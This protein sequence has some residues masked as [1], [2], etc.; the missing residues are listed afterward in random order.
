MC[1]LIFAWKIHD[2]FPLT[3][4]A[5]RDEL[6]DRP[7]LSFS[8]HRRQ[9]PRIV[10]GRDLSAGGTWLAINEYGVI[11]GL[12]NAPS[13]DGRDA[14]K[15]SRGELP[16]ILSGFRKAADGVQEF[17]SR[18]RPGQYNPAWLLVG[19][20]SHLFYIEVSTENEPLVRELQPGLHILE[21]APLDDDSSKVRFVKGELGETVDNNM[22]L[23]NALPGVLSSHVVVPPTSYELYKSQGMS[24]RPETR[25]PCVHTKGYGTR[26]AML[27]RVAAEVSKQP[28]MLVAD[29]CPCKSPFVDVSSIWKA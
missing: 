8:V 5:N 12:T 25:S 23:W 6:Y 24:R 17:M 21:N 10:G 28:E 19:D 16:L 9:N 7:S 14:S 20:R 13:P 22:L 11:S 27:V 26:S 29:G 3:I 18:V 4:A 1:L 2:E 15:R